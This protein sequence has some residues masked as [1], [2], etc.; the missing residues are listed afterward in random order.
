VYCAST[1]VVLI[2]KILQENMNSYAFCNLKVD[3]QWKRWLKASFRHERW[4]SMSI[5]MTSC[6]LTVAC[7][8]DRY[9]RNNDVI[10]IDMYV[11]CNDAMLF[12]Y[13]SLVL[14]D[15]AT[16]YDVIRMYVYCNGAIFSCYCLESW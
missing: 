7:S 16:N 9:S 4:N 5:A 11:Y 13:R 3:V 8:L 15:T 14:I 10:H 2:D 12:C 6:T 1:Y